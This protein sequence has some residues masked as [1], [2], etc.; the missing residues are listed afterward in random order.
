[1]ILNVRNSESPIITVFGGTLW[2]PKAC[3]KNDRTTTIRV[4][5]V[6]MISTAGR[7]D[8]KLIRRN[9]SITGLFISFR[10]I[11]HASPH[12]RSTTGS[13]SALYMQYGGSIC[14]PFPLCV[15]S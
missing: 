2:P 7:N 3:L 15:L 13:M 9:T 11:A 5:D 8:R 10:S 4:K 1:M 14:F 12:H 6:T